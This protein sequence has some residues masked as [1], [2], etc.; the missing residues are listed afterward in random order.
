MRWLNELKDILFLICLIFLI[1]STIV[2]WY[3]I[4]SDSML[5]TLDV[6][7]HII[8]NKLAYGLILPFMDKQTMTWNSPKRGELVVFES[9]QSEG[10]QTQ[11]KRVIGIPGD[12][13]SFQ[14]GVLTINGVQAKEI[15][16]GTNPISS[17]NDLIV[18]NGFSKRPYEIFRKKNGGL[19]FYETQT[20]KVPSGSFFCLGDNRDNSYDSR[21]WGLVDQK[22]IY[23][24]AF[25]VL[26][27]T[28]GKNNIWPHLRGDRWFKPI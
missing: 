24:K 19:T 23:G 21:F 13:I 12:T 6:G 7:D 28:G 4:P 5:P 11:I 26:Y 1:R 9:P 8:I 10:K 25:L 2:N 16:K 27:S 15:F 14:N 20:W 3:F 22:H 18:E 17:E